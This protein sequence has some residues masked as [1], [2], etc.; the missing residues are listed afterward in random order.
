MK[1]LQRQFL[2]ELHQRFPAN[3]LPFLCWRFLSKHLIPVRVVPRHIL[4]LGQRTTTKTMSALLG[5]VNPSGEN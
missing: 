2:G 3:G 5:K 1:S 4:Q